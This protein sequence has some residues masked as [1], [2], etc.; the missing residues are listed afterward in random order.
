MKTCHHGVEVDFPLR[1]NRRV[2]VL[3]LTCASDQILIHRCRE[4]AP[5]VIQMFVF[6]S[7]VQMQ[8]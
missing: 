8:K 4:I 7:L 3:H 1:G 6:P 5:L 2:L